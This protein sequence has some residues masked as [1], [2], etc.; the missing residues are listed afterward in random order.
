LREQK[1]AR[2][3]VYASESKKVS[4]VSFASPVFLGDVNQVTK[5]KEP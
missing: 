1:A 4:R 3:H 5:R 2:S